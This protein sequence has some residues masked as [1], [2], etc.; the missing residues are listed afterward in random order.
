MKVLRKF[1]GD[2]IRSAMRQKNVKQKDIAEHLGIDHASVSRWLSGQTLPTDEHFKA[3]CEYLDMSSQDLL[4][5]K[6]KIDPKLEL[7]MSIVSLFPMLADADVGLLMNDVRKVI[8]SGDSRA[9]R[10]KQS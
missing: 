10:K 4:F 1:V 9:K 6:K 5:P 7:L 2:Q 8:G 3:I